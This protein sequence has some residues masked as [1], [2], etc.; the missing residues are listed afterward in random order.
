MPLPPSLI[1]ARTVASDGFFPLAILSFLNRP[2]RPGPIFFSSLSALW[3]T[4]HCSKTTLPFAASPAGGA[5]SITLPLN[6]RTAPT[7]STRNRSIALLSYNARYSLRGDTQSSSAGL[8]GE[9][10][11]FS[12]NG[13]VD[14]PACPHGPV[15]HRR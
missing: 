7:A 3:Q 15:G 13:K 4:A 14:L 11:L 9:L 1:L 8:R 5:L 6:A 2:F 12:I 10:T